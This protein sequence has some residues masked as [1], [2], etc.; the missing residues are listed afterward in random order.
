MM[1]FF[2]FT[3]YRSRLAAVLYF[4]PFL[5]NRNGYGRH[6]SEDEQPDKQ[7]DV[8]LF[9]GLSIEYDFIASDLLSHINSMGAIIIPA[10]AWEPGTLKLHPWYLCWVS[11]IV[12]LC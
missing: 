2:R 12:S 4:R 11:S 8:N 7:V 5:I 10:A 3:I 6:L 9:I 1:E